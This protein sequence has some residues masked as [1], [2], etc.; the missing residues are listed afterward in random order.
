KSTILAHISS[1]CI[2][3][4]TFELLISLIC[5]VTPSVFKDN[6]GDWLIQPFCT[7]LTSGQCILPGKIRVTHYKRAVLCFLVRLTHISSD[8]FHSL[9]H[10]LRRHVASSFYSVVLGDASSMSHFPARFPCYCTC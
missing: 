7:S 2:F 5:L 8:H 4:F 6:L 1:A 3:C 9:C 10:H